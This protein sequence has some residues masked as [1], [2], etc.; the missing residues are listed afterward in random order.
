MAP[1]PSHQKPS[2]AGV[3]GAGKLTQ[4]AAL[5]LALRLLYMGGDD[6][7]LAESVAK[8][9]A[10][11]PLGD[12]DHILWLRTIRGMAERVVRVLRDSS[13]NNEGGDNNASNGEGT[14]SALRRVYRDVL[15]GGDDSGLETYFVFIE[16]ARAV[17]LER[18]QRRTGH[19]MKAGMLDS[20]FAT[21][22]SP[23]GEQGVV[24]MSLEDS[25]EEQV[26][27]A[28]Y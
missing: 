13:G 16:G 11:E 17:L 28:V 22:E 15:R 2:R 9:A 26:E 5:A 23:R 6:L 18:M 20:Q 4:G 27:L 10:G 14:C 21:L 1:K 19:F 3:S 24:V 8:M 25:T 7:H 12:E